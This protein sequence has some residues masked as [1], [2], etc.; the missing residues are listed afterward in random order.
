MIHWESEAR[1][2][3]YHDATFPFRAVT[4]GPPD[5]MYK[6]VSNFI[7]NLHVV[8]SRPNGDVQIGFTIWLTIRT[9]L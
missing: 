2:Q 7:L 8:H 4:M 9:R 6:C 3:R 1:E 5:A